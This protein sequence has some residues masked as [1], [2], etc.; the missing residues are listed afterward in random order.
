MFFSLFSK[1]P[2]ASCAT[3]AAHDDFWYGSLNSVTQSG[4]RVT[5]ETAMKASAC[6]AA[7]MVLCRTIA[8]LPRHIFERTSRDER[9]KAY[10]HPLSKIVGLQPNKRQTALEFWEM[11]VAFGALYGNAYAEIVRDA[12][13]EVAELLPIRPDT[14]RVETT[15]RGNVRYRVRGQG[16]AS[17]RVLLQDE[18]LHIPGFSFNGVEGVAPTLFANDAIGLAM[19]MEAFGARYFSQDLGAVAGVGGSGNV[20]RRGYKKFAAIMA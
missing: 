17:D 20:K 5:P 7:V 1:T 16:N 15:A 4:V 13:G 9:R 11:T 2:A 3:P 14:V 18:M 12:R 6:Y 8:P 19:V 10:D